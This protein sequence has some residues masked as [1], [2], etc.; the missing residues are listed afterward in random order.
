MA[1]IDVQK[2][3]EENKKLIRNLSRRAKEIERLGET[4]SQFAT[5][6]FRDLMSK[7]PKDLTKLT[8]KEIRTLNR[9]LK[10]IN[11]LKS[12]KLRGA[13]SSEKNYGKIDYYI[14]AGYINSKEMWDIYEKIG[15]GKGNLLENFKYE[16]LDTIV[17][18]SPVQDE[19]E[20]VHNIRKMFDKSQSSFYKG[21]KQERGELFVSLLD[22]LKD[23]P[24]GFDDI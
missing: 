21:T 10:Y 8:D 23:S 17:E 20:I 13:I 11:T 7:T 22:N 16:I 14:N 6:K 15:E 4:A 1:G 9:D 18:L 24:F 5:K 3:L 12:S 2:L 19:D